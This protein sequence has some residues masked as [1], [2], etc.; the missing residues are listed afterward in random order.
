MK[1]VA[2]RVSGLLGRTLAIGRDGCACSAE[3]AEIR[4]VWQNVSAF[5]C[6]THQT[7]WCALTHPAA[8]SCFHAGHGLEREAFEAGEADGYLGTKRTPVVASNL[9]NAYHSG[10]EKGSK[11]RI[12]DSF[13]L[14]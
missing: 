11:Q 7:E 1:I 10:F 3:A 6:R 5:P 9:S 14:R 8:V 4:G 13:R 2:V 12:A